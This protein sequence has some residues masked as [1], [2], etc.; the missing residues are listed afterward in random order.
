[1][2]DCWSDRNDVWCLGGGETTRHLYEFSIATDQCPVNPFG[3]RS[4]VQ[5]IGADSIHPLSLSSQLGVATQCSVSEL[6]NPTF[7]ESTQ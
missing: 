3:K 2:S 5:W 4:Y 7:S 1:M 6:R